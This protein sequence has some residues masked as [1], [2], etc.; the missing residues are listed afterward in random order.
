MK[1]WKTQWKAELD[2]VTPKLRKDVAD[3]PIN[4][5]QTSSAAQDKPTSFFRRKPFMYGTSAAVAVVLIVVLCV[6]LIVPSNGKN[7][8]YAFAVEINPAVALSADANGKVTGIVASNADADV[9]LSDSA[10]VKEQIGKSVEDVVKWYVDKAAMLGY[11]D[12]SNTSAVRITAVRGGDNL[13]NNISSVLENYFMDLGVR[14]FVVSD[15]V[16]A[17]TFCQ[18]CNLDAPENIKGLTSYISSLEPVLRNRGAESM[19]EEQIRQ[20]YREYITADSFVEGVCNYLNGQIDKI[21]QNER[22]INALTELNEQIKNHVDNSLSLDYWTLKLLRTEGSQTLDELLAQ[23]ESALLKYNQ[24]YGTSISGSWQLESIAAAYK[25]LSADD[26]RVILQNFTADFLKQNISLLSTIMQTV[27]VND[28]F[29]GLTAL[30]DNASDFVAK[31]HDILTIEC[32]SRE[33]RF[34]EVYNETRDKISVSD[35]NQFKQDLI[36]EYGSE[37]N[38]WENL[39]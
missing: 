28:L 7:T 34:S 12:L 15:I 2:E 21:A 6:T 11:L 20:R 25:I 9:I 14:S 39:K 37:N 19:T 5:V 29:A 13:L 17:K 24:T 18:R 35:Y 4:A 30:P 10:A 16:D 22:D 32:V 27:S 26:L 36:N 8:S 23:M 33:N 38:L 3:S 31:V 1:N